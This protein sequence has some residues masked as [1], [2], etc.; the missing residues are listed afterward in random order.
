MGLVGLMV[1]VRV[2]KGGMNRGTYVGGLL[3][4]FFLQYCFL[5]KGGEKRGKIKRSEGVDLFFKFSD[6]LE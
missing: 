5:M 6:W 1:C 3:L 2:G 4:W